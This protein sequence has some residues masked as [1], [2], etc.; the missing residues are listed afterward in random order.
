[1]SIINPMASYYVG[2]FKLRINARSLT[3][4]LSLKDMTTWKIIIII[5]ISAFNGVQ[6]LNQIFKTIIF[7]IKIVLFYGVKQWDN[8]KCVM[9][10]IR[11]YIIV[12]F[13][14]GMNPLYFTLIWHSHRRHRLL[15]YL[16]SQGGL[17]RPKLTR[18]DLLRF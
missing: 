12:F 7:V 16:L 4:K 3:W 2:T 6:C 10:K 11:V 17:R 1:M 15:I 14:G 18:H 5:R 9:K 13:G 8:L